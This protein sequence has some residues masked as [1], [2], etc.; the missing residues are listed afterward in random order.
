VSVR[1]KIRSLFN[2][3]VLLTVLV[4]VALISAVTTIRFAIR[5]RE[6]EVPN[7]VGAPLQAAE[8]AARDQGLDIK[9]EDKL[10]SSLP[11][12]NVVS[13]LPPAGTPIKI[14]QHV[15]VLVSLGPKDVAVPEVV[16]S[17][18]RAAEISSVQ[19]GLTVGDIAQIHSGRGAPGEIIA[20]DPPAASTAVRGPAINLLVSL[21]SAA[22]AYYCPSFVGRPLAEARPAIEKAG[23]KI[24]Q[25]V[26][27]TGEGGVPGVVLSQSPPP[28]SKI[29]PGAAFDFRVA[30]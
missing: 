29:D 28:G 4:A 2:I 25:I 20:Q 22:P 15:D 10:Y 13:Q 3:V 18:L 30:Q 23:F 16:G 26:P 12:G 24:G 19:R 6:T 14:G 7:L 5:G 8:R 1:D 9:V 21:G 27:V 11:A 17:S